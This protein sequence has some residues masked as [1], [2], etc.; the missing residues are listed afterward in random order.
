[1]KLAIFLFITILLNSLF[2][3]AQKLAFTNTLYNTTNKV[4]VKKYSSFSNYQMQHCGATRV[5]EVL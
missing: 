1:M 4:E 3:V 2:A 5:G